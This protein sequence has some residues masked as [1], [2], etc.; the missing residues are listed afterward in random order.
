[1]SVVHV[2]ARFNRSSTSPRAAT[3]CVKTYTLWEKDETKPI[4]EFAEAC[5]TA[6]QL[7]R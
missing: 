1:M 6:M 4:L 2:R 5:E 7:K 3:R